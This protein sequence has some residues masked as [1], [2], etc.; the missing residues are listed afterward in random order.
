MDNPIC[1]ALEEW[2]RLESACHRA[3]SFSE[4]ECRQSCGAALS[5]K[6]AE[7]LTMRAH[8]MLDALAQVRFCAMFLERN[9][10][11]IGSVAAG[12]IRNAANV[13]IREAAP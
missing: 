2:A 13:L 1:N 11:E 3:R 12:A 5:A 7:I 6:E 9:G 4:M 8:T 10:G